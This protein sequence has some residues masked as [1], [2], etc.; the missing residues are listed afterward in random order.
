MNGWDVCETLR[1]ERI[2]TPI[3]MLTA[4]DGEYDEAE[5][6]DA[7]GSTISARSLGRRARGPPAAGEEDHV[8]LLRLVEPGRRLDPGD[9][10]AAGRHG[11][12]ML[13][14]AARHG[15]LVLASG[16]GIELDD[17]IARALGEPRLLRLSTASP[18]S[19]MHPARPSGARRFSFMIMLIVRSLVFPVEWRPD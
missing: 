2:W 7:G 4:K 17:D 14:H 16:L 18:G 1:R 13:A 9:E 10:L 3:L 15:Q 8:P 6:L 5:E 19:I 11:D 12:A